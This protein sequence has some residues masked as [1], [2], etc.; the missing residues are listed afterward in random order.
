M[1]DVVLI[2][3]SVVI[4]LDRRVANQ[5]QKIGDKSLLRTAPQRHLRGPML[6]LE[7]LEQGQGAVVRSNVRN[8][9]T[10][11]QKILCLVRSE[12]ER[13][14]SHAIEGAEQNRKGP[15]RRR[16]VFRSVRLSLAR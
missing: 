9:Q 6:L 16:P 4:A 11:V 13:E 3:Q 15:G 12:L 1:P 10:P 8:E 14:K 7:F 2:R 5:R